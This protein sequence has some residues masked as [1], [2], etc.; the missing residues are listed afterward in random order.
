MYK[1]FFNELFQKIDTYDYNNLFSIENELSSNSNKI[2]K[3][4]LQVSEIKDKILK[5]NEKN[6]KL[7]FDFI[8]NLET[9]ILITSLQAIFGS[10]TGENLNNEVNKNLYKTQCLLIMN[11]GTICTPFYLNF[12]NE[13]QKSQFIKLNIENKYHSNSCNIIL[14]SLM[15]RT[16]AIFGF[17]SL[18]GKFINLYR[19]DYK[20]INN[21]IDVDEKINILK[22]KYQSNLFFNQVDD[23]L[24]DSEAIYI[25]KRNKI[26]D[27][28]NQDQNS[29]SNMTFIINVKNS[30]I[31]Y[32]TENK[33]N[34]SIN[35]YSYK[36]NDP[37]LDLLLSNYNKYCSLF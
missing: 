21:Y 22:Q 11:T 24:C 1:S 9:R 8:D 34:P 37:E 25:I 32:Y 27:N 4:L 19:K 10:F 15:M 18:G 31:S 7:S 2:D 12:L 36:N 26:S 20:I 13:D 33:S 28:L 30:Q 14:K 35:I 29:T 16:N 6:N 3:L 5:I 17:L 23:D